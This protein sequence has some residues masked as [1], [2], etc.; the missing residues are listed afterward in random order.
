MARLVVLLRGINVGGHKKVPMAELRDLA[1]S[2]GYG[3]PKTYIASGNLLIDTDDLPDVVSSAMS[4]TLETHF[5]FAVDVVVRTKDKWSEYAAG[6]AFPDAESERP[7]LVHVGL[8]S[9]P[10]TDETIE[11][12]TGYA[13]NGELVKRVGDVVWLD[14]PNGSGTSKITPKVLDRA[15]GAPVTCRNFNSVLK[16]DGL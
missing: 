10:A 7:K 13:K 11:T 16:I 12:I 2:L 5:G 14:Y 8:S 15:F 4:Q 1:S 9:V 3:N 6:G